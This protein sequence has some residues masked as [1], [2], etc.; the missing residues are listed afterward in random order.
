MSDFIL[1]NPSS[2]ESTYYFA[3]VIVE[4]EETRQE[5][6]EWE[7]K[8]GET[9]NGRKNCRKNGRKKLLLKEL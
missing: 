2:T 6:P 7:T 3:D 1:R 9:M 8:N 4:T 5:K